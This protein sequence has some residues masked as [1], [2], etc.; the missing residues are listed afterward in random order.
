MALYLGLVIII[1]VLQIDEI[2]DEG[3]KER[4]TGERREREREEKGERE[5]ER[6]KER[7]RETACPP[8][9]RLLSD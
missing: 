4:K 3:E 1:V 5:K 8:G 9:V 7:E 2:I 6:R